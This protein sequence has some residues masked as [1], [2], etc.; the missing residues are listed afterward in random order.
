MVSREIDNDGLLVL[1]LLCLGDSLDV[2]LGDSVRKSQDN[3]FDVKLRTVFGAQI[4]VNYLALVIPLQLLSDKLSGGDT[5][6]LYVGVVVDQLD[7]GL[8]GVSSPSDQGNAGR[9]LIRG[10]LLAKRRVGIRYGGIAVASRGGEASGAD[11]N[12][13]VSEVEVAMSAKEMPARSQGYGGHGHRSWDN[14][15]CADAHSPG[16][17]REHSSGAPKQLGRWEE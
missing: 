3:D 7:Q 15:P 9:H 14:S 6:E 16:S 8:A 10:I 13:D 17:G 1:A 12:V 5:V 11:V 4:I 2:W